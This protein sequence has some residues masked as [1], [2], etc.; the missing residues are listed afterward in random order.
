M[1]KQAA[2]YDSFV[3]TAAA[4]MPTFTDP[5]SVSLALGQS[6]AYGPK[7]LIEG[8]VA[9]GA[10]AALQDPVFVT[11]LREAGN[12]PEHREKMVGYILANPAYVFLFKDSDVAAGLAREALGPIGVKMYVSGKAVR[13]AAYDIQKQG[14]SKAPVNDLRGRLA[15]AEAASEADMTPQPERLARAR[16]AVSESA[17][18][19]IT[20]SPLAP[21]YAPLISRALQLAAI[22]A[23]GEARDETYDRLSILTVEE[24]AQGCL[25]I[26]KRN[27]HQCLA[28]AKP[29]YEDIFCIGQ[30][31][32][33]DTG[34]CLAKG[35]GVDLP[36]EPQPPVPPVKKKARRH[37]RG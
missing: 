37:K 3:R 32:L 36:P 29:N 2:A 17:P 30:H 35:A 21:P 7:T 12:S 6:R 19:P 5:A 15:A 31:A 22:A 18:L 23:L 10:I 8:A 14:W 1:I 16:L 4:I 13:Q 9:Y 11:A 28:V 25:A 27:F 20:A 24:G 34:A 26:A 33:A